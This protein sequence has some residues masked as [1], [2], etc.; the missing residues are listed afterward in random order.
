MTLREEIIMLAEELARLQERKPDAVVR[1]CGFSA[2]G[3]RRL[4]E[5]R[6]FRDSTGQKMRKELL[7][8]WPLG[9]PLP[10]GIER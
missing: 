1:R 10:K 6:D 4:V 8:R 7:N 5:G 3:Y 2:Y 9:L